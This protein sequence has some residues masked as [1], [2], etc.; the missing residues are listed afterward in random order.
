M[1]QIQSFLKKPILVNEH[2]TWAILLV[3]MF[4]PIRSFLLLTFD[5]LSLHLSLILFFLAYKPAEFLLNEMYHKRKASIKTRHNL[6][7]LVIYI[8][9]GFIFGLI[10]LM[11]TRSYTFIL[12]AFISFLL[13]FVSNYIY[14]KTKFGLVRELIAI[15]GL[16]GTSA[17]VS[18]YFYHTDFYSAIIIWL[19][20]SLFFSLSAFYIHLKLAQ[21]KR[22]EESR[23]YRT[24]LKGSLGYAGLL[25][26]LLPLLISWL[27]LNWI[28]LLGFLP[29]LIHVIHGSFSAKP[30]K[31]FKVTG[32]TFLGY[33]ILF[34]IL[35]GAIK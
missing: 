32:F 24:L 8:F 18:L 10:V 26:I 13:F 29:M 6:F 7:W 12:P 4:L 16:T 28:I 19:L 14:Y 17:I 20:C 30:L 35:N 31:S 23:E 2:G 34:Y 27:Q 3:P 9:T 21:L 1:N 22:G 25:V 11:N 33:S 15:V 5:I